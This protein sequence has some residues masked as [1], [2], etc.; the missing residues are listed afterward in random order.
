MKNKAFLFLLFLS[1]SA[2]NC[3]AMKDT[4]KIS[5]AEQAYYENDREWEYLER[6]LIKNINEVDSK[7]RTNVNRAA[8]AGFI[9]PFALLSYSAIADLDIIKD[10][11]LFIFTEI[12]FAMG[13][14]FVSLITKKV[15]QIIKNK[16]I[17]NQ[18]FINTLEMF[19]QKYN[20]RPFNSDEYDN[21]E[22]NYQILIP[23]ELQKTFDIL[24]LK[25]KE[26]G[27]SYLE[28]NSVEILE[29]I[30]DKIKYEVKNKKY[31]EIEKNQRTQSRNIH[32]S[33]DTAILAEAIRSKK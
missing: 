26:Y 27:R 10:K 3:L 12:M 19:L 30:I 24:N 5:K 25:Y 31:K 15:G 8:I 17:Q 14:G 29:S 11:A 21:E 7:T 28:E 33:I 18:Q 16:K 13:S 22:I 4:T 20:D 23:K 1:I 6:I 2:S 9:L 32:N